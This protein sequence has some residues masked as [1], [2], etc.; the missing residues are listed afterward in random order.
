MVLP[1][2]MSQEIFWATATAGSRKRSSRANNILLPSAPDLP[3]SNTEVHDFWR[4]NEGGLRM[5]LHDADLV[6][7][8]SA[9]LRFLYNATVCER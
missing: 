9:G 3:L 8:D 6:E 5:A 7:L 2:S 1:W 4:T